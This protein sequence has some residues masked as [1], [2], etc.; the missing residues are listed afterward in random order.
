MNACFH[1]NFPLY[2]FIKYAYCRLFGLCVLER[3]LGVTVVSQAL[4]VAVCALEMQLQMSVNLSL[5]PWLC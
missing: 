1:P 5:A 2:S 3:Q 4:G